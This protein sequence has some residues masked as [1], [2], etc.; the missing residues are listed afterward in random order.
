LSRR[1]NGGFVV[2]RSARVD[3][4]GPGEADDGLSLKANG[5]AV[6]AVYWLWCERQCVVSLAMERR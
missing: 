5:A 1:L 3:G 6:D 2:T 4:R